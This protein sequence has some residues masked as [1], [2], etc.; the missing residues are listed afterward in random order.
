MRALLRSDRSDDALAKAL[1]KV[2]LYVERLSSQE[3]AAARLDDP[4]HD[5]IVVDPRLLGS[6]GVD[7][8]GATDGSAPRPG[9]GAEPLTAQ[10][11]EALPL[12]ELCYRRIGAVLDQLD[13]GDLPELYATVLAQA[14]RALLRLALE[15]APGN[16]AAAELLGI[17]RNTFARR[18]RALGLDRSQGAP[19][20]RSAA[21][22]SE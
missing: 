5:V 16:T 10:D 7:G 15:R 8:A 19:R 6:A 2:G 13:G 14:E 18:L 21:S 20:R 3:E 22:R 11:L 9:E 12:E 4:R 1:A 17:H